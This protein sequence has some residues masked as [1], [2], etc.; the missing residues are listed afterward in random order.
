MSN[1]N[2]IT[3]VGNVTRDPELR[4]T[5]SGQATATFGIAVN[6]RWQNRQSQQWEEATSF[7]DVVCWREMAENASESLSKGARVIVTG[8]LEQR[9]WETQEGE[10]RSKIEIIA[11]E[12]GPSLRWATAQIVRNERKGFGMDTGEVPIA[13]PVGVPAPS[14]YSYEEEPF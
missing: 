2:T 7:F 10:K 6:R 5:S 14:A 1:G 3:I 9:N 11:D 8:R 4:F 13:A 12:I